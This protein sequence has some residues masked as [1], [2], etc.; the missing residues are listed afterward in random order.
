MRSCACFVAFLAFFA[1]LLTLNYCCLSL[2]FNLSVFNICVYHWKIHLA[3]AYYFV[4]LYSNLFT[5]FFNI[6]ME[7]DC[8]REWESINCDEESTFRC[9][10]ITVILI[11]TLNKIVFKEIKENKKNVFFKLIHYTTSLLQMFVFIAIKIM[12]KNYKYLT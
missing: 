1:Q 8:A 10:C 12:K 7:R 4:L 5:F 2:F 9:C 11:S 3:S 6:C